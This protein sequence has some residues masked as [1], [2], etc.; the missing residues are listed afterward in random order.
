MEM[1]TAEPSHSN[2][3]LGSVGANSVNPS[4]IIIIHMWSFGLLLI[5]VRPGSYWDNY[6]ENHAKPNAFCHNFWY[7]RH[8]RIHYAAIS[9]LVSEHTLAD[10]ILIIMGDMPQQVKKQVVGLFGCYS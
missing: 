7:I 3:Q 6:L 9:G 5:H 8:S 10:S 2:T 4:S 1:N